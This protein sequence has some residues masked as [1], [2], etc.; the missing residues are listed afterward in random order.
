RQY[1][2]RDQI[3]QN[4]RA[5][6]ALRR[7]EKLAVTGRLAASIAHEINNP[8]EAVTNLLYLLR[9][10]PSLGSLAIS[11]TELAQHEISRVAEMPQQTLRFSRQ[12]SLPGVANIAELLDSVLTLYKGRLFGLQ[13][14]VSRR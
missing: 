6:E 9:H 1:Q 14:E 11:Y 5:Q 2:I 4:T 3:Q 12:S 10:E 8:L 7:S 13:I